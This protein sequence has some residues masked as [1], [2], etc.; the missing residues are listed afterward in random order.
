M[1][2]TDSGRQLLTAGAERIYSFGG[3]WAWDGRWLIVIL[4]VPEERRAVRHQLKSRLAWAGLG[5]LGGGIWLTPH[6]EREAELATAI[7]DEPD[8]DARSFVAQVGAIGDPH[9]LVAEAWDLEA[10]RVQYNVLIGDF[11]RLRPSAPEACFRQQTMLVHAWRRFPFLDPDLPSSLLPPEWPRNRAHALFNERHE[12]WAP[13]ARTHF[14]LL[15][16]NCGLESGAA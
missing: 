9:E 3:P 8:A 11:A 14:D 15:E 13:A 2:L 7:E 10:V 5:S 16:S 6:A 4:R 1:S 12:Q